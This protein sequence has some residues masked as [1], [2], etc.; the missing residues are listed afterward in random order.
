MPA[1]E[2]RQ[3]LERRAVALAQRPTQESVVAS[4]EVVTVCV[5]GRRYAV[6][7]RHISRILR[8][9]HLCRL[10]EEGGEL[11]GLV[12][13][14][15]A[16]VP[17]A[18]LGSMLGLT[19]PDRTRPFVV[20]LDGTDLPLGLLVDEVESFGHVVEMAAIASPDVP[21]QTAPVERGI[22]SDGAV[23]LDADALLAHPGVAVLALR[24]SAQ[25]ELPLPSPLENHAK[26]DHR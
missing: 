8:T 23:L 1:P 5:G 22:T 6:E 9:S 24:D 26:T 20:L 12:V 16:A 4:L 15:G 19:G 3:L 25:Q 10:P 17:V 21:D 2:V 18:D 13:A 14:G 11:V 7:V